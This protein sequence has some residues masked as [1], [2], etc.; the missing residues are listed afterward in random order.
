MLERTLPDHLKQAGANRETAQ[1]PEAEED[2]DVNTDQ[3]T[4]EQVKTAIKVMKN[5]KA[6]RL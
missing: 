6:P 3:P 1:I 5:G 4:F 2:V